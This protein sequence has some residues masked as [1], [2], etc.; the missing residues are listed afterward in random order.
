MKAPIPT[1]LL[2][3]L[4]QWAFSQSGSITGTVTDNTKSPLFG[5]NV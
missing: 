2:F 4:T 3:I 1:L 5:V